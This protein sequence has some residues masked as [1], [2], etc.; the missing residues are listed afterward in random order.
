MDV[1][2]Q[3]TNARE[4][5]EQQR[6]PGAWPSDDNL[7]AARG[8]REEGDGGQE[9]GIGGVDGEHDIAGG[10][11]AA[12]AGMFRELEA[13]RVEL[14]EKRVALDEVTE[15]ETMGED[16]EDKPGASRLVALL[17]AVEELER[18]V[19]RLTV[20]ADEQYA[21]ELMMMEESQAYPDLGV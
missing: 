2:R 16:G 18:E 14:L 21:K 11:H 4:E 10:S 19:R 13:K 7:M 8:V 9:T 6:F 17:A 15:D 5:G 20:H 1:W 3:R 12:S